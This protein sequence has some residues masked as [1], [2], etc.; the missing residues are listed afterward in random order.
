MV[1]LIDI[2]TSLNLNSRH[3]AGQLIHDTVRR[4]R[5]TRA[6]ISR[7]RISRKPYLPKFEFASRG[8]RPVRDVYA[9]PSL[10]PGRKGGQ[11][12]GQV[13]VRGGLVRRPPCRLSKG[14]G[15]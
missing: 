10:G 9:L 3:T 11:Y 7:N 5:L 2:C 13:S 1:I 15:L 6:A 8:R 4:R 12:N 14:G